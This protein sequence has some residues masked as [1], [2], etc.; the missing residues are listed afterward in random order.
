M[1][2]TTSGSDL[3]V[4]VQLYSVRELLATDRA[5]TFAA[6]AAGGIGFLEPYDVISDPGGLRAD[7]EAA[8]LAIRSAHV[9]IPADLAELPAL[10]DTV[11]GLGA[12]T[13][14]VP[15]S[16]PAEWSTSADIGRVA[17]R[18]ALVIDI[19]AGAGLRVAYHNHHWEAG[20]LADG[21]SGLLELLAAAPSELLFQL[22]L[23]WAHVGGADV[24]ELIR[25][26]GPRLHSVHVKDGPGTVEGDQTVLGRG[27]LGLAAMLA[28][29]P[30]SAA[31]ILEIDRCADP[32]LDVLVANRAALP[33]M[34][35]RVSEVSS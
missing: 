28:E 6:L 4:G 9:K 20:P 31:R 2:E 26:L 33:A 32:V 17:D 29:V 19:A 1:S 21:R 35:S 14:V 11:A 25:A 3:D 18:L 7:A 13:L 15:R 22:D 27:V 24:V 10:A 16:E 30:A 34:D 12:D 5:A 23:Y 8:G